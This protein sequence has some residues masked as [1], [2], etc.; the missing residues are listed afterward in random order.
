[1]LIQVRFVNLMSCL[2]SYWCDRELRETS[3][4]IPCSH[5]SGSQHF[6]ALY[7]MWPQ[8]H[9]GNHSL[10][11]GYSVSSDSRSNPQNTQGP[12]LTCMFT[13][14]NLFYKQ[15]AGRLTLTRPALIPGLNSCNVILPRYWPYCKFFCKVTWLDQ[16]LC[17]TDVYIF[18]PI[19]SIS[20]AYLGW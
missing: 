2:K 5:L 17:L 10:L 6:Q 4:W 3:C 20:L 18:P 7:S 11:R 1:M 15:Q 16:R 13:Q 9:V 14:G 19:T 12:G 8:G